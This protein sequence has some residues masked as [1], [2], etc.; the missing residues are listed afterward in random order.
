MRL[1]SYPHISEAIH[2]YVCNKE[3]DANEEKRIITYIEFTRRM[4]VRMLQ[5]AC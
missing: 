4:Y 2:A 3:N 1:R 5:Y